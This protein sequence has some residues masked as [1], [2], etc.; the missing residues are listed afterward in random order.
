[1]FNKTEYE[2]STLFHNYISKKM[3]NV[4]RLLILH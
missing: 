1:M 2:Y 3:K 4:E